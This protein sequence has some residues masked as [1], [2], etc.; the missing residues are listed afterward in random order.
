MEHDQRDGRDSDDADDASA[1][2]P[3]STQPSSA[4][5]EAVPEQPADAAS[6]AWTPDSS[7]PPR[8]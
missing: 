6:A 3:D 5:E 7:L 2:P 4:D 8:R 1:T